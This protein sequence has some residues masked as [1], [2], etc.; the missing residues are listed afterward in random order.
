MNSRSSS[1]RNR[2]R[3]KQLRGFR[4]E[5]IWDLGAQGGCSVSDLGFKIDFETCREE[6]KR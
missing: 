4:K 6:L 5:G 3:F 2:N 1:S